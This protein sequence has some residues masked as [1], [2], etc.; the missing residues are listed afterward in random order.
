MKKIFILT[1]F[2][3]MFMAV[4]GQNW[5]LIDSGVGLIVEDFNNNKPPKIVYRNTTWDVKDLYENGAQEGKYNGNQLFAAWIQ[6]PETKEFLNHYG[7]TV[8][9]YKYKLIY[10]DGKIFESGP[11][12]FHK[13]GYSYL[14]I[15]TGAFTEGVWKIEWFIYNRNTQQTSHVATTVFQTT[16]GT[17][18]KKSHFKVNAGKIDSSVQGVLPVK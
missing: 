13:S 17:P 7:K 14:G 6:G 4:N 1:G 15:K 11:A 5:T 2:M 10:P 8:W 16:W 18:E 9:L 12:E 3:L